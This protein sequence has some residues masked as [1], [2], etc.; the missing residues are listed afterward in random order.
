[1]TVRPEVYAKWAGLFWLLDL[2][3]NLSG[4][5]QPLP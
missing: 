5:A 4:L 2:F 1:M 3:L